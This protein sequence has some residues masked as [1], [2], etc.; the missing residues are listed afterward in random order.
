MATSKDPILGLINYILDIKPYHSKIAEILIDFL[1][2]DLVDVTIAE[3]FEIAGTFVYD[4][5][6]QFS[7]NI[8][9]GTLP[10]GEGSP[11]PSLINDT[12]ITG[13]I[14]GDGFSQAY[15]IVYI[16]P[17][18]DRFYIIGNH[19]AEFPVDSIMSIHGAPKNN[20]NWKVVSAQHITGEPTPP[21]DI[22]DITEI[23]ATFDS[24][25]HETLPII[26]VDPIT[27]EFTIAGD[28]EAHYGV[29][30]SFTVTDSVNPYN[31]QTW[32]IL[33]ST[34]PTFTVTAVNTVTKELTIAGNQTAYFNSPY[35]NIGS[36]FIY[37]LLTGQASLSWVVTTVALSGPD[38]VITVSDPTNILV[39]P[40]LDPNN[41]TL[42]TNYFIV[43]VEHVTDPTPDGV[44]I[45]SFNP[46]L[47]FPIVALTVVT[48]RF[49]VTGNETVIFGASTF[50]DV[51]GSTGNDGRWTI[52]SVTFDGI[53]NVTRVFGTFDEMTPLTD[54]VDGGVEVTEF[55]NW[56]LPQ[57]CK[58]A[59][60]TTTQAFIGEYLV[61]ELGT[62]I[63]FFD[64]IHV[65]NPYATIDVPWGGD[66]VVPIIGG[67]QGTQRFF[68]NGDISGDLTLGNVIVVSEST[69][70]DGVYH[71]SAI[72]Y[73]GMT[74][75]TEITVI[76]AIPS[77]VFDGSLEY[78]FSAVAPW[79]VYGYDTL[80][81][82]TETVTIVPSHNLDAGGFIDS[83]DYNFWDVGGW[84]ETL[85]QI[86]FRHGPPA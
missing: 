42:R 12:T 47:Q 28:L 27:L 30:N 52:T 26:Y 4:A 63:S 85:P 21:V 44:M 29:G 46:F 1:G 56:D 35:F 8:G 66:D 41:G 72:V 15:P 73:N 37:T 57:L 64:F 2:N 48:D 67:N 78:S 83:W 58:T 34:N 74:L 61:F 77:A 16:N 68:V 6:D 13:Y 84:D 32:Q 55:S 5:H 3:S 65:P 54:P 50:F 17:F 10:W 69:G 40:N 53:N 71:I 25:L 45:P 75:E 81:T 31:G 79:D 49:T 70:N 18:F 76:E 38:T 80:T 23:H 59:S 33:T 14:T 22:I 11:V 7:C 43:Q 51:Q 60:S 82:L 24:P 20:G 39:D 9:Y 36:D 86:V 19:V 62:E